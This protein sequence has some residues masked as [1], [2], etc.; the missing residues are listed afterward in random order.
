M[1]NSMLKSWTEQKFSRIDVI[2]FS[3]ESVLLIQGHFLLAIV[4]SI[5]GAF[6]SETIT[7]VAKLREERRRISE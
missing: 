3:I 5:A 1:S 4:T 7:K 6:V 2:I